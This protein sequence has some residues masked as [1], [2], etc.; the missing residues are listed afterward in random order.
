MKPMESRFRGY[1]RMEVTAKALRADLR[2][3]ES[4]REREAG[5]RTHATF[6]VEDGRA[7]PVRL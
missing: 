4:V 7:G 2:A 3:M 6:I 1:V 5:C